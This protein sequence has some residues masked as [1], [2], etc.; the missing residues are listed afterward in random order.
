MNLRC[1]PSMKDLYSNMDSSRIGLC[2][3]VLEGAGI[4]SYIQNENSPWLV[5]MMSPGVQP[6]LCIFDDE[7]YDEAVK[8]LK[9][10]NDNEAPAGADWTC[11]ECGESNPSSFEVCWSCEAAKISA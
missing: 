7:R 3:S 10:L 1:E 9:P 2:Q 11:A 6:T 5:N 8:L 4:A